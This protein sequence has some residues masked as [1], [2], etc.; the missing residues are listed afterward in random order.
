M[1]GCLLFGFTQ[2]LPRERFPTKAQNG[3]G[4]HWLP[5]ITNAIIALFVLNVL[6]RSC[7]SNWFVSG[8]CQFENSFNKIAETWFPMQAFDG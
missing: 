1:I 2:I 8:G 3:N 6:R 7:G 5:T 4:C